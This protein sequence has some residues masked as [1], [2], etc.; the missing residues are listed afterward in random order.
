MSNLIDT[1]QQVPDSRKAH[2]RSHP[3]WISLALAQ[4]RWCY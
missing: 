4:A 2:S 1:L 3:L